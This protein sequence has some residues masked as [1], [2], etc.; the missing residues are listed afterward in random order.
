AQLAVAAIYPVLFPPTSPAPFRFSTRILWECAG[1]VAA[2]AVVA[3]AG[4]LSGTLGYVAFQLLVLMAGLPIRLYSCSLSVLN[5][6][7]GACDDVA[8][9]LVVDR[10]PFWLALAVGITLA[11][12]VPARQD[13]SNQLLR[14]AGVLSVCTTIGGS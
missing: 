8:A 1:A 3:R 5:Q 2:G 14:A 7:P 12:F 4:G 11:R 9:A 13:G 10:W 6:G